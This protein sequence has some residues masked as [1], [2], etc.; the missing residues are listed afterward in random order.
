MC[1]PFFRVYASFEFFDRTGYGHANEVS[2]K[3]IREIAKMSTLRHLVLRKLGIKPGELEPLKSLPSLERLDV[4]GNK[5][6]TS[7]D[8]RIVLDLPRLRS[9]DFAGT[10][11]G[12]GAL[13]I[14]RSHPQLERVTIDDPGAEVLDKLDADEEAGAHVFFRLPDR[15]LLVIGP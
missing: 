5:A 15:P 3:G 4:G 9:V 6:L 7:D 10:Q 13:P 1:K 12:V 2:G 11:V 8:A 14:F